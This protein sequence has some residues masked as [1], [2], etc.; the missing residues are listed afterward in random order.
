MAWIGINP[1][2]YDNGPRLLKTRPDF[3]ADP[4]MRQA[5][6]MCLD[7]QKVVD[8]VLFGLSSVPASF[9]SSDHPLYAGDLPVTSLMS[10]PVPSCSNRL[11]GNMLPVTPPRYGTRFRSVG[12]QA[13]LP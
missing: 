13:V 5:I 7:R 3:F 11:A 9:V 12:W 8:T 6:A 10:L 2:V 1:A 4:L